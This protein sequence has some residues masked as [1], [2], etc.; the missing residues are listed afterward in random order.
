M[1]RYLSLSVLVSVVVGR[2]VLY[3][4]GG[5]LGGEGGL[6]R[7]VERLGVEMRVVDCRASASECEGAGVGGGGVLRYFEGG[8]KLDFFGSSEKEAEE[9]ISSRMRS[10]LD[11][12]SR[13]FEQ[14]RR[15]S[16]ARHGLTMVFREL[17]RGEGEGSDVGLGVFSS[18]VRLEEGAAFVCR[19]EVVDSCDGL[20]GSDEKSDLILLKNERRE[21]IDSSGL[22]LKRLRERLSRFRNPFY[23]AFDGEFEK[24]VLEEMSPFVLLALPERDSDR[25]RSVMRAFEVGAR[26]F[27]Q[28]YRTCV[29]Y[30]DQA[31]RTQSVLLDKLIQTFGLEGAEVSRPLLLVAEPD[32]DTLRFSQFR[33]DSDF[34]EDSDAI[35]DWL[36][37]TSQGRSEKYLRNEDLKSD[38][39]LFFTQL[40]TRSFKSKVF[41]QD[42][43][44]VVLVHSG[45]ELSRTKELVA[46]LKTVSQED[47]F[48]SLK[49]FTANAVRNDLP[50]FLDA[51]P[52]I[53]IFTQNAWN[54]PLSLPA[55]PHQLN[56]L[57]KLLDQRK[58]LLQPRNQDFD[59][60]IF[61]G[62]L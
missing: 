40:N 13:R 30:L 55:L 36:E 49:F 48:R 41:V 24:K 59:G 56:Q 16:D 17:R 51:T 7:L 58:I 31:R 61:D 26:S 20:F 21:F 37:R 2:L 60:D 43:E 28:L 8:E 6:V 47:R 23:M 11:F 27:E 34:L 15:E 53:L 38:K 44:S 18:L 46:L 5:W 19:R 33:F 42:Q 52:T 1:L 54:S 29:V 45:L 9:F 39:Y 50:V 4:G 10:P 3:G 25:T 12:S 35:R 14:A 22:G 32:L 57:V 62:T